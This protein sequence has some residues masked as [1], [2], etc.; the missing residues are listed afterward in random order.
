MTTHDAPEAHTAAGNV[1]SPQT[2][3][4]VEETAALLRI[5]RGTAYAAIRDGSLPSIRVGKRIL[6][7]AAALDRLLEQ[8][9]PFNDD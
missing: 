5:G 2:T 7:P 6:V 4:T 9:E 3:L 1:R 8:V